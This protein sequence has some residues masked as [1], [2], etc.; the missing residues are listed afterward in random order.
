M[1]VD[2]M[3]VILAGFSVEMILIAQTVLFILIFVS[4]LLMSWTSQSQLHL[5]WTSSG[6][7]Q[8]AH[9]K[10]ENTKI[11]LPGP[12]PTGE[13]D[14][15]SPDPTPVGAFDTRTPYKPHFWL[16]AWLNIL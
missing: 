13:G 10:G 3:D 9:F 12:T 4:P 15:T 7:H 5:I 6:M 14:T 16:R 1:T 11:F 2:L 8:N